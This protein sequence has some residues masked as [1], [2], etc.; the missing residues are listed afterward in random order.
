MAH[1]A[2]RQL[3]V[4]CALDQGAGGA[5][6]YASGAIAGNP[7]A[8]VTCPSYDLHMT[9]VIQKVDS[10]MAA[11]A[12]D[13]GWTFDAFDPGTLRESTNSKRVRDNSRS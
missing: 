10:E 12:D 6:Y 4:K 11:L 1:C 7:R 3:H 13:K 2:A 8:H 9:F 5:H